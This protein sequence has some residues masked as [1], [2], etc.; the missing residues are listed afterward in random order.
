MVLDNDELKCFGNAPQGALGYGDGSPRG[1]SAATIGDNLAYVDVGTGRT[2]HD[3]L[4]AGKITVRRTIKRFTP[5]G[6]VFGKM[7]SRGDGGEVVEVT[8]SD[9]Q[10]VEE[11]VDVDVVIM[12]TG[13]KQHCQF[14]D[15]SVVDLRWHRRGNDV[16]LYLGVFPTHERGSPLL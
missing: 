4:E 14:V 11:E 1:I 6:I 9:G 16:P 5:T 2:V 10:V 15:P 7:E 13:F 8:G 12:A 3:E